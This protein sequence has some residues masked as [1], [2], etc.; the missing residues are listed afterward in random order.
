VILRITLVTFKG[1]VKKIEIV[2]NDFTTL[3]VECDGR[4]SGDNVA[5]IYPDFETV[6][7]GKFFRDEMQEA[8]E[9]KVIGYFAENGLL[10]LEFAKPRGDIFRYWPSKWNEVV[11]PHLQEDPFEKKVIEARTSSVAGEF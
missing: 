9:S 8:K 3:Q 1:K 7:L 2:L 4:F 6:L 11:C 5:Y 10:R